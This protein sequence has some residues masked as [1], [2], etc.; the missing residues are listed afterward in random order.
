MWPNNTDLPSTWARVPATTQCEYSLVLPPPF[1]LRKWGIGVMTRSKNH[2]AL[3]L[4]QHTSAFKVDFFQ[5]WDQDVGEKNTISKIGRELRHKRQMIYYSFQQ[6]YLQQ[7]V[8]ISGAFWQ[9]IEQCKRV[10]A[11]RC[12][13]MSQR[14]GGSFPHTRDFGGSWGNCPAAWRRG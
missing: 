8:G 12:T 2:C 1:S 11:E 3:D 14:T 6:K 4:S 9:S 5:L 10:G 7:S 13:G